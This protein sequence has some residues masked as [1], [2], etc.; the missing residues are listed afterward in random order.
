[1]Q[2]FVCLLVFLVL[3]PNTGSVTGSM[4]LQWETLS[5]QVA[6]KAV[7][8]VSSAMLVLQVYLSVLEYQKHEYV[9]VP[10]ESTLS[11]VALPVITVCHEKPYKTN[12]PR[13]FFAGVDSETMQFVG[14]ARNNMTTKEYL[15]S[16]VTNE[17]E[18]TS[19]V[20]ALISKSI[21]KEPDGQKLD[22]KKLRINNYDGQCFFFFSPQKQTQKT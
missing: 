22:L 14:W 18:N 20:E 17:I 3:E 15:E 2:N 8:L 5:V 6:Q 9:Q 21:L 4:A 1:M 10:E 11:Q 7:L 12:V 13:L 19:S 16:L